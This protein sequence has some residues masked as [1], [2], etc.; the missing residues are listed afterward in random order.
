MRNGFSCGKRSEA[1]SEAMVSAVSWGKVSAWRPGKLADPYPAA[2]VVDDEE[3]VGR[4]VQVAGQRNCVEQ[5]RAVG[6][7]GA[8]APPGQHTRS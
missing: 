4:P 1:G 2:V 6:R 8:S 7:G 3:Q 5:R